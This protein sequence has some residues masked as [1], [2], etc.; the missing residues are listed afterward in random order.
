[1]PPVGSREKNFMTKQTSSTLHAKRIGPTLTPD[2]SRVLLRPFRPTTDDISRRIVARVMALPEEEVARLL[3]Q[4]LGE[5]ANRHERVEEIFRKRFEQVAIYLEPYA[6]PSPERQMLI[7]AYF[8]HEYSPESTALFNP[9]IVP[10]SDQSGLPKGA[11]RFI[12][13][14]R[15][16]GEGHISSITFRMG[17]V[18]AHHRIT[19]APAVPF[20]TEPER[21]P[22]AAYVKGLFAHKLEEAGVQ[23]DFCRRVLDK[24]HEDFT[25]KELHAVLLASG[26]TDT[27]DATA[28]RAARGILLLAESNYEVNFAPDSRVSQRV[29]FPSAPSQSNGIEDARFVR[30]QNDDGSFTY[31]ATYTAYDGKITLP[32]LLETPDFVHFKFSTLNGPAVQNKGMALFPRKINGQYAMLSRQDDENILLMLSE[33]IHFW[34]T[35]KVLLSPAQPWEFFKIGNC[36]SPIETEAG[37]LVLSHGVGAMRKYCLGAFLLDL[38]DP[39][40][41]IGRLREPLLSPNEAEREGYVP[42][43][44]YTCG[45]LLHGRELIIPYAMSDSA[46][47]FA[48]VPLDELLAAME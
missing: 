2:R 47:S 33:N 28:I 32:Q 9:S 22:D 25:L 12:L 19:L 11:L 37:W 21:V 4:V 7:G 42:N 26:L 31:Y 18:S 14:L 20:V 5:F 46:T 13:S 43:V 34:Q 16:T 40:R 15:A 38:N 8:T 23:N 35:P 27:S 44:V 48:T 30:F 24:L 39:A 29:L 36:G 1:M 45:A 41:V 17:T 6:Q 10:H 3:A